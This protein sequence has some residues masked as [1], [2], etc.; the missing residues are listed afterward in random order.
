MADQ[1]EQAAP[2]VLE[3][4]PEE[5]RLDPFALFSEQ[6][7]L[8]VRGLAFIGHLQKEFEFCGHKFV[9]KTLRPSEK[10]AIALAIQP[11][12]GT[13]AEAEIWAHAQVAMALVSVD[14]DPDFCPAVGP[15]I[16][17]FASARLRFITNAEH[18]WYA[19]TLAFLYDSYLSLEGEALAAI[20]ELRN[21]SD[22]S[23]VPSSPSPDSLIP[24]GISAALTDLG[25]QP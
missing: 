5:E 16:V 8:A 10:A 6:I 24:P 15:N 13:I 22:G 12:R 2:D 14:D 20:K 18:G 1:A 21:F 19:P 4:P 23:R 11:W 9:L 25:I 17:D 7:R 3:V